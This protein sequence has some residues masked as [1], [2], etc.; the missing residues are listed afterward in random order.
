MNSNPNSNSPQ[1]EIREVWANNLEAEIEVLRQ[2]VE[3]YNY[4]A[5]DTGKNK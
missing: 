3:K 4:I 2:L 1:Y 5:M